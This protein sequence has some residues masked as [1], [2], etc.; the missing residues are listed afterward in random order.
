[1]MKRF[2]VCLISSILIFNS[3]TT[4]VLAGS[5]I[6]Q[7]KIHQ[8]TSCKKYLISNF[9]LYI[10]C[11][12]EEVFISSHF[13]NLSKNKKNDIQSLLAI[14]NI[15]QE[16]VEDGFISNKKVLTIWN[17]ILESSYKAKIKKKELQKV[18][19]Q[20]TCMD[21][22]SYNLFIKCFANEFRN[23]EIYQK[24][25]LLNK[26]RIETIVS[27]ALS[28]TKHNSKVYAFAKNESLKG[29]TYTPDQ[30]FNYFITYM[31]YLGTD[32]YKKVKS[33]VNWNKVIKF[34]IIA[35]I[36]AYLSKSLMKSSG[37]QSSSGSSSASSSTASTSSGGCSSALVAKCTSIFQQNIFRNA[38]ATSVLKKPWFKYGFSKGFF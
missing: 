28:L 37:G 8:I 4:T 13:A 7:T 20:T 34:I 36:I 18:L 3:F 9:E 26:R 31:N 38:P 22:E 16:N 32:Y 14:S 15:L 11:L 33:D 17:Q 19:E 1:M 2:I 5:I 35:I 29:T 6:E 21:T 27:N 24:S 23:F 30:G 10:E 12:N 25:D